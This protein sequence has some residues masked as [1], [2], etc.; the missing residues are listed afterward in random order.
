MVKDAIIIN[1][2]LDTFTVAQSL[3]KRITTV[4]D[5]IGLIGGTLSLFNGCSLM[6]SI[7]ILQLIIYLAVRSL[8]FR[9]KESSADGNIY[10]YSFACFKHQLIT[11][12]F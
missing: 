10:R 9:E 5:Q 7:E 4:L 6:V 1:F 2:V 3:N 12:P 8:Q 11:L